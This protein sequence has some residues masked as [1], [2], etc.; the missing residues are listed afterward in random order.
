MNRLGKRLRNEKNANK[1][2]IHREKECFKEKEIL[3]ILGRSET[4]CREQE[5]SLCS[6]IAFLP[7]INKTKKYLSLSLSLSLSL[8]LSLSLSCVK[9]LFSVSASLHISFL[10][11][12][13]FPNTLVILKLRDSPA[14][15]AK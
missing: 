12:K 11:S 4:T 14:S 5:I 13:T 8:F 6:H 1:T 10:F 9:N 2:G 7:A 15:C 3:Q